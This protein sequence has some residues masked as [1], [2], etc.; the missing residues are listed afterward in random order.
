MTV[1]ATFHGLKDQ[2]ANAEWGAEIDPDEAASRMTD[3]VLS[4]AGVS[5]GK[6]QL[7]EQKGTH[8][9]INDKV[10]WLVQQR[11]AAAGTAEEREAA[12]ACSRGIMAEYLKHTVHAKGEL[13]TMKNCSKAW[14]K[15]ARELQHRQT[16]SAT[17][18]ALRTDNTWHREPQQKAQA[19]ADAFQAKFGL[20]AAEANDYSFVPRSVGGQR[21]SVLEICAATVQRALEKLDPCSGTGPDKLPARILQKCAPELCQPLCRV[22]RAIVAAGRWPKIWTMHWVAPIYKRKEQWSP[23]NYR[24][25]HLTSQMSKVAER[26]L[27]QMVQPYLVARGSFGE[28]QFA[29]VERRGARDMLAY[30]VLVWLRGFARAQKYALYCSDVSGA[31][32]RVEVERMV[33]KLRAAGIHER[34]VA[35]FS[36]WLRQRVARVVVG[37][38]ESAEFA[39]ANMVFQGTVLGPTFWNIFFADAA[40]A[41]RQTGFLEKVFADDLSAY[42][43]YDQS[44]DNATLERDA[45]RCQSELHMW[46]RANRVSFD[47][48]KEGIYVLSRHTP[49]GENFKLLG[50]NF[51][52]RLIMEDE[53]TELAAKC[54]WKVSAILSTRRYYSVERMVQLYKAQVLSYVEYRTPAVF[55][56]ATTH[57]ELVD[58]VQKRFLRELGLREEEGLLEFRLAPLSVRR[59]IAMLGLIHRTALGEGPA[60]FQNIFARREVRAQDRATRAATSAH[61]MQMETCDE[62][63]A[64]LS[65]SAIGMVPVY[66]IL[67]AALVEQATSVKLLQK[68]LQQLVMDR[69][70]SSCDKWRVILT[71]RCHMYEHPL[72]QMSGWS[73]PVL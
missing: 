41:V 45:L 5:I 70:L 46:G 31:F 62:Q 34:L 26:I 38:A 14:W 68:W 27:K 72:R 67:P 63:S 9:W 10:L 15:K 1:Q 6:R 18:P 23:N 28:H 44:V 11:R 20:P 58:R 52:P 32:D 65:R 8:P 60:H 12:E 48:G 21:D 39:L 16:A 4:A 57:L 36:S 24:G 33:A 30:M 59:D 49:Q 25:V 55:H 69:A 29:Y 22:I 2:L 50:I 17:I 53:L 61:R 42:R 51:D 40:A 43:P 73:P 3:T 66:N 13:E 54:H 64:I 47:A 35:V 7:R 37:G 19:L 71:C 56:A